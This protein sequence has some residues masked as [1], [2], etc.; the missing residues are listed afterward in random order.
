GDDASRV[1]PGDQRARHNCPAGFDRAHRHCR[2]ASPAARRAPWRLMMVALEDTA[3][4]SLRP[5]QRQSLSDAVAEAIA[6][7]IASGRLAPGDRVVEAT[8]AA[9]LKVSRIPVREALKVL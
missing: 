5:P 7:G 2:R 9:E 8:I 1:H 3:R 4:A 6:D